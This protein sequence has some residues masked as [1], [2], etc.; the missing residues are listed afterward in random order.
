MANV[1]EIVFQGREAVSGAIGKIGR[2]FKGLAGAAGKLTGLF[3]GL[4]GA[5]SFV[6]IIKTTAS[7]ETALANV[8]TLVDT[9]KV[10]MSELQK[11]VLGL[12]KEV[13]RM[14][15]DLVEGL[16]QT[17][18][19]GAKPGQEALQILESSAKLAT[20]GL[21]TTASAV[22]VVTTSINAYGLEASDAAKISD[23]LFKTVEQGKTTVNALAS[24]LGVAIP[25][26]ASLGVS[27]EEVSSAVAT[28]TK[29]GFKTDIAVT[30]LNAA[31]ASLLQ[32]A[33]AFRKQGID[34]IEVIGSQGLGGGLRVLK[35]LTG[36]NIE[37][38]RELIPEQRALRAV[39]ALTGKQ[40]EEYNKILGIVEEST[41][42][43]DTAFKKQS[44]TLAQNFKALKAQL[45]ALFISI[46][47]EATPQINNI[48]IGFTKIIPK[49]RE[50]I[51][52]LGSLFKKL[53]EIASAVFTSIK[54]IFKSF[55]TDFDQV[56]KL[57]TAF[58][59]IAEAIGKIFALLMKQLVDVVVKV[60]SVIWTPLGAGFRVIG[61][62]I[63][64]IWEVTFQ[65]LVAAATDGLLSIVSAANKILPDVFKV[66]TTNLQ[67]FKDAVDEAAIIPALTM[68]GAWKD[69]GQV[70]SE[71]FASL[72]S[73]FS[74]AKNI[75]KEGFETVRAV[76]G[77][78]GES[79]ELI[80]LQE[81]LAALFAEANNQAEAFVENTK[82][83]ADANSELS[84]KIRADSDRTAAVVQ[85]NTQKTLTETQKLFSA[86]SKG[87]A[88]Y[89]KAS[90]LSAQ[91]LADLVLNL[92]DTTVSGFSKG[93][94]QMIVHGK[95]AG[96]IFK[97]LFAAIAETAIARLTEMFLVEVV[98]S[99]ASA[100][101]KSIAAYAGIPIVGLA[102]GLAAGA[103]AV[104]AI[105]R[106][107]PALAEGGVVTQPTVALIG[108]KGPEA[109]IPLNKA[110][111][112]GEGGGVTIQNLELFPNVTAGETILSI[113]RDVL[114]RWVERELLPVLNDMSRGGLFADVSG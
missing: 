46:G 82:T 96:E 31:M 107:I 5:L 23:I 34:I 81:K 63:R 92:V 16:Y 30:S 88:D 47:K 18:S 50:F 38:L 106:S 27:L 36:G 62:N 112:F 4:G 114:V 55:F 64:F 109:V 25:T 42:A 40:Y 7:F 66:D 11:G 73:D 19:A 39:L 102:L 21:T 103:A 104:A 32:S 22:D 108:E 90:R 94:A 91:N 3:A 76:A 24:T 89:T 74:E 10:S 28:L 9:T 45:A 85:R 37:A 60:S 20:A 53:P 48:I 70:I 87:W 8:E 49:V 61:D 97:N 15:V 67:N 69:S 41:G 54:N 56:K 79:E 14:P 58:F 72:G 6:E 44:K 101:V 68:E 80:L 43:T 83:T 100:M 110:G 12:S 75:F 95:S 113:P 52:T 86:V 1:I 71:L 99:K 35:D 93:F 29:G 98:I 84:G 78:L 111:G 33:D 65:A 13:N 77:E 51:F 105:S 59:T 2:L 26:A 57:G 17:I